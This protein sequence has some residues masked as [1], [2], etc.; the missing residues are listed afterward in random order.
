MAI[1]LARLAIDL[2]P[3]VQYTINILTA[4]ER[5]RMKLDEQIESLKFIFWTINDAKLS[6][7]LKTVKIE[8]GY[9]VRVQG[10]EETLKKFHSKLRK[11]CGVPTT[12]KK[13][14]TIPAKTK[15]NVIEKK[16]KGLNWAKFGSKPVEYAK[17]FV[18]I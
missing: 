9:I 13:Y 16:Y 2:E 1:I 18:D 11:I 15:G 7:A 12:L 3:E 6:E 8:Q 14:Y 4:H 5:C 17:I 10:D